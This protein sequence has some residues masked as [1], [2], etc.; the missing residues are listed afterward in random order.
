MTRA[1]G[2]VARALGL[3]AADVA[4]FGDGNNDAPLL[5]WA[6]LGVALAHGRP[7]AKAAAKLVAPD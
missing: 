3:R 4:A 6:G 5:A 7:A 2:G 1:S